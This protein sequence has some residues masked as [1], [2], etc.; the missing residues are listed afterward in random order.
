[1]FAM[2]NPLITA[3]AFSCCNYYCVSGK[4][5]EAKEMASYILENTKSIN[6]LHEKILYGELL[7]I[8]IVIDKDMEAA[9]LFENSIKNYP[10]PK[11]AAIEKEQFDMVTAILKEKENS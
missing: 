2:T 8:T 7:F 1:M 11:D 9:K 5:Q 4:Y 6:S 3:Q 10:Y